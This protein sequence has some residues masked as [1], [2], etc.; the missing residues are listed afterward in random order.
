L[1]CNKNCREDFKIVYNINDWGKKFC[2]FYL[3]NNL[4]MLSKI[5]IVFVYETF[6][7]CPKLI[8]RRFTIHGVN[9]VELVQHSC[10][11]IMKAYEPTC[12]LYLPVVNKLVTNS[13]DIHYNNI[14]YPDNNIQQF[15]GNQL[16]VVRYCALYNAY[17]KIIDV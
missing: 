3:F 7:S 14:Y 17:I 13:Y 10:I 2:N 16:V 1:Q 12:M 9:L 15:I 11:I 6:K 8:F 5:K 4:E